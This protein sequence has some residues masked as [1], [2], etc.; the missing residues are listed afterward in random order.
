[1]LMKMQ[2]LRLSIKHWSVYG[3]MNVTHNNIQYSA[4]PP[5][6][7]ASDSIYK[8]HLHGWQNFAR[9]MAFNFNIEYVVCM[10]Q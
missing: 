3:R 9:E 10:V 6:I 5:G 8:I 7:W 2:V 4:G 1:M